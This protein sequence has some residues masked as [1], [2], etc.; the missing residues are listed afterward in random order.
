MIFPGEAGSGKTT[1]VAA[2]LA[3]GWLY[4]S[5]ELAV[6]NGDDQHVSPL[7]LPMSIKPGSVQPLEGYYP[8]LGGRPVHQREDGKKVRYLSPAPHQL[9]AALDGSA[10]VDYLVFPKFIQGAKNRLAPLDKMAALQRLAGT[11]SSNRAFTD[12]D[13]E[14][15]IALVEKRPCY[16]LIFSDLS[17]AVFLIEKHLFSPA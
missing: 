15:M 14:A 3:H 8:K 2:L 7:P 5:D 17:Q 9:P 10:P 6:L 11:G 16:E 4:F 12:R 13:V 1:L